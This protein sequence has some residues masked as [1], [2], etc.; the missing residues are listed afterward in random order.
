[1][2]FFQKSIQINI[3]FTFDFFESK[4]DEIIAMSI[5]F[6][7]FLLLLFFDSIFESEL[8]TGLIKVYLH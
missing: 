4:V 6:N 8:N 5:H 1:M 3:F 7:T 2:I